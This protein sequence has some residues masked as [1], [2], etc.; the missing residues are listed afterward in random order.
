MPKI[1]KAIGI[2]FENLDWVNIPVVYFG[3]ISVGAN[4]SQIRFELLRSADVAFPSFQEDV[5]YD[6]MADFSLLERIHTRQDITH[7]Y[8][9]YTDG[10]LT[11][12]RVPW[13]DADDE[14]HNRLQ[15]S[16]INTSG[17]LQVTI[18]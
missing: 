5:F 17:N 12:L 14:Y 7:L 4:S 10:S 1:L 13:E 3:E 8:L 11:C 2:T 16:Y 18:G 15:Q 9:I 6:R